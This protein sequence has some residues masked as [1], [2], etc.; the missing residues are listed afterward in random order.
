[1]L[2]ALKNLPAWTRWDGCR[3]HVPDECVERIYGR[4]SPDAHRLRRSP[5]W[6]L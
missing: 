5:V 1:M 6:L 2:R 3:R 4:H